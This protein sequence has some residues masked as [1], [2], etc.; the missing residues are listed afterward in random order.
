M[1]KYLLLGEKLSHSLSPEIH[2]MLGNTDYSLAEM[3]RDSL[4][5]FFAKRD[6]DGLNVTVPYKKDAFAACDGLSEIARTLGSVN[7]VVKRPDGTL[8]GDNTDFFGF[9]YLLARRIFK[10]N[11]SQRK[12]RSGSFAPLLRHRNNR[13]HIAGWH[14]PELRRRSC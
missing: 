10:S 8:F 2:R 1:S 6:F 4:P 12:Q 7:T 5:A 9:S 14:V 13:E 11:Y 3:S